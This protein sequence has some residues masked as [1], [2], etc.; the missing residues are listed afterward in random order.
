MRMNIIDRQTEEELRAHRRSLPPNQICLMVE[1]EAMKLR[2]RDHPG[3][4]IA[5]D[6]CEPP[7]ESRFTCV[8][9]PQDMTARELVDEVVFAGIRKCNHP[10]YYYRLA[11]EAHPFHHVILEPEK[12]L[13][14]S[15]VKPFTYLV[16]LRKLNP[17]H[18]F[19]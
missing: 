6:G 8:A 11:Y 19:W 18:D 13:A 5:G 4:R 12:T 1:N 10:N 16:F 9:V 7:D 3:I 15:G 17:E 14:E 2:R